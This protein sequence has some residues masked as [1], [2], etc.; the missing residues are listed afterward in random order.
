M[1]S[2][3]STDHNARVAA[4]AARMPSDMLRRAV[5][6]IGYRADWTTGITSGYSVRTMAQQSAK[7]TNL[8]GS[9]RISHGKLSDAVR[10]LSHELVRVLTVTRGPATSKGR[11]ASFYALDF[12]WA[13]DGSLRALLIDYRHAEQL[14]VHLARAGR[15]ERPTEPRANGPSHDLSLT[16]GECLSGKCPACFSDASFNDHARLAT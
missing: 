7:R 2:R 15:A 3:P 8:G 4:L 14:R 13:D 16:F 6:A 10:L 9:Y 5:C 11:G 12:D 1:N